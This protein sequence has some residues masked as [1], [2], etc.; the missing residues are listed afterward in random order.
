MLASTKASVKQL[1]IFSCVNADNT[2]DGNYR[3]LLEELLP[4]IKEAIDRKTENI[5]R[6]RKRE[7]LRLALVQ[8]FDYLANNGIFGHRFLYFIL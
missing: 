8:I 5:K 1:S 6:K 4:L 2:F 3:D 7:I